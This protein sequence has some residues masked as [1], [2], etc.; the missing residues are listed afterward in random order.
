MQYTANNELKTS[1]QQKHADRQL[2]H[3]LRS[4]ISALNI[5]ASTADLN[6][7]GRELL[8]L[9]IDRLQEIANRLEEK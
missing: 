7:G 6:E 3:D 8:L 1:D 9:A 2:A 4:P 5:L